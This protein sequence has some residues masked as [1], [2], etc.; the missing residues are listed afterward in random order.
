MG[1][2]QK[3]KS[4]LGLGRSRSRREDRRT[5]HGGVRVEHEPDATSEAAV[6]GSSSWDDEPAGGTATESTASGTAAESTAGG[7]RSAA[8]D[9]TAAEGDAGDVSEAAADDGGD[10]GG[11]APG[12]D[13]PVDELKGIGSAYAERLGNAGIESVADLAAADAATLDEE[14]DIGQGRIE[15]WIEQAEEY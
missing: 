11:Q 14:T 10:E 13:V 12:V 7:T 8:A 15:G 9:E 1:L 6:K 3:L 2:L 4:A 5:G